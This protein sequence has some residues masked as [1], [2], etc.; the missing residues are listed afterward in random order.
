MQAEI[1]LRGHDISQ[2]NKYLPRIER[3]CN[4]I[5]TARD[6]KNNLFL[7]GPGCNLLSPSYGGVKMPDGTFGKGYLTGLSITYCA[8]LER[9]A[10]LYK[11]VGDKE[12]EALYRHRY[13]ITRESL[14]Q[15]LTDKGYFVKSMEPNGTKHGVLGQKNYAYLEGVA[16]ADAMCFRVTND[17]T[18][19]SIYNQ[20]AANPIIRPFDFLL[21]N[22]PALDDTYWCWGDFAKPAKGWDFLVFGAWVDGGVWGTVEGRAIMGYYRLGQYEDIRRSATRAMKWAKDYRMDEPFCQ[23]G[24]TPKTSGPSGPIVRLL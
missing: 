10:E 8:A 15:L 5:E 20:I 2:I 3:A 6:P 21:T 12:K 23:C 9:V 11:I 22:A 7:V 18:A 24:K 4:H 14:G 17:D 19:R 13:K 1:L 16:N